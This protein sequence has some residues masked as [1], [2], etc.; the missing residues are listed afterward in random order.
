MQIHRPPD[1]TRRF[2][3]GRT[4]RV[5]WPNRNGEQKNRPLRRSI[6][7]PSLRAGVDRHPPADD[8]H[9]PLRGSDRARVPQGQ[10]RRLPPRLHRPGGGGQR[11]HHRAAERAT[12][13]SPAI[14]TTPTPWPSAPIRGASWPSCSA[15]RPASRRA[16]AARCICSTSSTASTAATAS[17]ADT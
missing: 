3:H 17:S 5:K 15:K 1:A 2:L 4:A 14:A 11:H 13:S 16:R 10:D 12:S 8:S 6:R 9:P 7:R